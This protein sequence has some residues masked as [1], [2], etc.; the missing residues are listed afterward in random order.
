MDATFL[1]LITDLQPKN[2]TEFCQA[3]LEGSANAATKL[4][5]EASSPYKG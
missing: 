3:Y 2:G 5:K 4:T 1:Q